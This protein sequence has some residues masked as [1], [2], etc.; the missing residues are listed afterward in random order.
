MQ[1]LTGRKFPSSIVN[2]RGAWVAVVMGCSKESD[3][4]LANARLIIAA[5]AMLEACRTALENAYMALR[6][7]WNRGDEGFQAQI[8]TLEKVIA[9]AEH[10]Q[11][12]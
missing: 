2:G 3:E 10:G 9:E 8:E 12:N 6:G 5:P 4:W 11:A 1:R 7:E